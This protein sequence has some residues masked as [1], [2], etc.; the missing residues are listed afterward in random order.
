MNDYGNS[1]PYPEDDENRIR[2][3]EAAQRRVSVPGTILQWF[4]LISVFLTVIVLATAVAAPDVLFKWQYDMQADMMNKQPPQNRQPMPPYEE[5]VKTQ[6]MWNVA[7]GVLQ[8][9]GGVF[10]FIGGAKM[11]TLHGYGFGIASAILAIIPCNICCCIGAVFGI[12]ALVVLLNSDVKLAFT[13]VA[14]GE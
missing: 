11:K 2:I 6:Q 12:W 9:I 3:I 13:K 1:E 10:I 5:F 4:G 8:L 7:S 14:A